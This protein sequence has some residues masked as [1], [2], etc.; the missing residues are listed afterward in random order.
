MDDEKKLIE[1]LR[2][3]DPD[4]DVLFRKYQE[5]EVIFCLFKAVKGDDMVRVGAGQ[6]LRMFEDD[7]VVT[8][9]IKML[10][11]GCKDKDVQMQAIWELSERKDTRVV[12]VLFEALKDEDH[13]VQRTAA[14]ALEKIFRNCKTVKEIEECETQLQEGYDSLKE[15]TADK[16][17]LIEIKIQCAKLRIASAK[18]KNQ[19]V[20]D[21]GDLLEMPKLPKKKGMYRTLDPGH[22][23]LNRSARRR[24]RN[25]LP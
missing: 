19:L 18:R 23:M 3:L 13:R 14:R 9:L 25:V 2:Y 4:H 24:V 17:Q 20:E 11:Q 1:G 16:K 5:M 7:I 22:R 10:E 12:P 8:A 6:E 21:K 15:G